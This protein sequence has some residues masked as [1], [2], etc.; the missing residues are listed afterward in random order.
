VRRSNLT[1]A[2]FA[3]GLA[4]FG[5][6]YAVQA[7]L[8]AMSDALHLTES[9]ASLAI[10]VATGA[11]AV[12]VLPW[13]AVADRFGRART[14]TVALAVSAVCGLAI[15]LVPGMPMLLVL[16]AISGA[17]LAA[18][19]ALAMAHVVE[20]APRG[21]AVAAGGTYIAGTTVGGLS[22]RLLTGTV[23][24]VVGGADGWRWGL[25]ATA[26]AVTVLAVVFAVLLPRGE[27]R[28]APRHSGRLRRAMASRSAWILYAQ[29]FLLMGGFVTLYNLLPFRLLAAPYRIPASVVS[30]I[31]VTYLVGTAG[32]SMVGR[33]AGRFGRRAVVIAGGVGMALGAALTITRPLWLV[34]AGLVMAT[35]GFFVTHAIAAGWVGALLPDARSQATAL[36]SLCYYLGSS[37]LGYVGALIFTGTGWWGAAT[38]VAVCAAVAVILAATLAPAA[39]APATLAPTRSGSPVGRTGSADPDRGV[40]G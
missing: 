29:G 37:A 11:L 14:M 5:E 36:Y 12:A 27:T 40:G 9:T 13:A 32:S 7:V 3:G 4:T 21:R 16:R 19:P 26:V 39:R 28:R 17:A 23:A 6:L 31:F 8:P 10:S 24:G 18:V 38:M 20:L 33:L 15:P 34:V 25:A 22:G 30:L 2:M 1:V 35:F